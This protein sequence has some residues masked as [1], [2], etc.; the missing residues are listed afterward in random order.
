MVP[1]ELKSRAISY[2]MGGGIASALLGSRLAPWS[3]TLVPSSQY[4]GAFLCI[5]GLQAMM[6]VALQF[7]QLPLV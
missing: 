5:C 1:S 2:V 6:I 7:V 4:A 3:Q